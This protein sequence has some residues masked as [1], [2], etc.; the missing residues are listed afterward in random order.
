MSDIDIHSIPKSEYSDKYSDHVFEQY[1]LYLDMADKI[2]SRRHSANTFFVS[3]NT[4]LITL[5]GYAKAATDVE[6]FFYLV[7]SIAGVLICYVW[8]RLVLSYKNLNSAKFKVIHAIEKQLPLRLFDAEWD[9]VE[10][11]KNKSLY[12]PFT[13]LEMRVPWIFLVI[14]GLVFFYVLPW[15]AYRELCWAVN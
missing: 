2:T 6:S 15:S 12:H 9:A 3:I 10:R 11:G 13:H 14:H 4:V 7:T 1:K 5:A 8:Y